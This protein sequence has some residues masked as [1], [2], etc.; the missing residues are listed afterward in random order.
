MPSA[1]AAQ[2]FSGPPGKHPSRWALLSRDGTAEVLGSRLPVLALRCSLLLSEV[3]RSS[4]PFSYKL[5]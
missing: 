3:L 1:A 2:T 4:C 5:K